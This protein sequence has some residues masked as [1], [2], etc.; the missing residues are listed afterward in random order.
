[1]NIATI[2]EIIYE[3]QAGN[4]FIIIDDV[5]RE[6]EG[7]LIIAAEKITPEAMNFIITYAKG[8]VCLPITSAHAKK[9]ELDIIPQRNAKKSAIYTAPIDARYG[10]STGIS[11]YDRAHT[12]YKISNTECTADDIAIPGHIF[13]LIAHDGGIFA[14]EGHTEASIEI[15]KLANLFPAAVICEVINKDGTMARVS[16]LIELANLHKMKITTT[17]EIKNYLLEVQLHD[18]HKMQQDY[19]PN[20]SL[21]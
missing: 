13:P 16:D 2:P 7:D 20:E 10:I 4:I 6:N 5:N 15:M 14:R 1:M 9:L 18:K 12:V 3:A 8:M 17:E 21:A 11:A 19:K